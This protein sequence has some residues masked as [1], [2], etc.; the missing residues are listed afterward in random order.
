MKKAFCIFLAI[1]TLFSLC[2]CSIVKRYESATENNFLSET[3][4]TQTQVSKSQLLG[5]TTGS[6]YQNDFLGLRF[7]L[8][9]GWEFYTEAQIMQLNNYAGSFYDDAFYEQIQNA[10]IIYDMYAIQQAYGHS[11]NINMEKLSTLQLSSL[12]IEQTLRSQFPAL[13]ATLNN[14]GYTDVGVSYQKVTVDGKVF[15]SIRVTANIQNLH[16]YENIFSFRKGDYLANITVASLGNDLTY[17]LL[18][19]FEID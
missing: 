14:M 19:Q 1:I 11:V 18:D 9:A 15:D 2:G 12:D 10:N 3:P 7:S 4:G 13:R 5:T 17:D 6:T 16:L 8:P